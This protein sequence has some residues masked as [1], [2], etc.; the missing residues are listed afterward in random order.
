MFFI[1]FGYNILSEYN[2]Q[3]IMYVHVTPKMILWILSVL[4]KIDKKEKNAAEETKK[5]GK[6][7]Y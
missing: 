7:S 3:Y 5:Q 6:P 4:S 1:F 2:F